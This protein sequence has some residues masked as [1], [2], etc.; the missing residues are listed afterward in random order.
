VKEQRLTE[1]GDYAV[2]GADVEHTWLVE[3]D[4]IV[5]TVRWQEHAP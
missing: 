3:Q 4:A 5:L 1:G 2:W